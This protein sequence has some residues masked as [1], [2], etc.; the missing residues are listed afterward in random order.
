MMISRK[1]LSTAT[2]TALLL[3][4]AAPTTG[5][6]QYKV[7]NSGNVGAAYRV[8]MIASRPGAGVAAAPTAG[9][10]RP[11]PVSPGA[12]HQGSYGGVQN[13]T[14]GGFH[15]PDP[16]GDRERRAFVAG[17]VTGAILGGAIASQGQG[18][19]QGL[20]GPIAADAIAYCLQTYLSYDPRSGTYIGDDGNPYP[21][22]P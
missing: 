21:C 13:G 5:F 6:A 2:I 18:Y 17:A 1:G 11:T 16:G 15:R 10:Y 22:P 3:S 19:N 14:N 7:S 9:G 20:P 12:T 4:M 8:P